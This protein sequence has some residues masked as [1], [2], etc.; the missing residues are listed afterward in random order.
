MYYLLFFVLGAAVAAGVMWVI[1]KKRQ[2]S[3]QNN[4]LTNLRM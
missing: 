1:N 3:T 4:I 2:A